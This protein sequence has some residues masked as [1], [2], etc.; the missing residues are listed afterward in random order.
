MDITI[1]VEGFVVPRWRVERKTGVLTSD[2]VIARVIVPF[3]EDLGV[4]VRQVLGAVQIDFRL[5]FHEAMSGV[6]P[7]TTPVFT[8]RVTELARLTKK[9]AG[10]ALDMTA[11]D[12]IELGNEEQPSADIL[13]ST[14]P[15]RYDTVAEA[16]AA[17]MDLTVGSFH[18]VG[19]ETST[20]YITHHPR[21][22]D[23]D[24]TVQVHG[25]AWWP[26]HG[27]LVCGINESIYGYSPSTGASYELARPPWASTDERQIEHLW[28]DG[29]DVYGISLPKSTAAA[30]TPGYIVKADLS[31][32]SPNVFGPPG[33]YTAYTSEPFKLWN[34]GRARILSS[35]AGWAEKFADI[36]GWKFYYKGNAI[37]LSG[38]V[39]SEYNNGP[40]VFEAERETA[41]A[42]LTYHVVAKDFWVSDSGAVGSFERASRARLTLGR[43]LYLPEETDVG[44]EYTNNDLRPADVTVYRMPGPLTY[45]VPGSIP[46]EDGYWVYDLG[47]ALPYAEKVG[48]LPAMLP[49]GY[50][51]FITHGQRAIIHGT[52]DPPAENVSGFEIGFS[53]MERR[54]AAFHTS[55][56]E[57]LVTAEDDVDI[58]TLG[59]PLGPLDSAGDEFERL[60]DRDLA[61]GTRTEVLG[62]PVGAYLVHLVRRSAT[63]GYVVFSHEVG[64]LG[65]Y[66]RKEPLVKLEIGRLDLEGGIWHYSKLKSLGGQ[67]DSYADIEETI[68]HYYP[69]SISYLN[70][71]LY[72]G[73]YHTCQRFIEIKDAPVYRAYADWEQDGT[74]LYLGHSYVEVNGYL[75]DKLK[76]GDRIRLWPDGAS[77][78]PCAPLPRTVL[79]VEWVTDNLLTKIKIAPSLDCSDGALNPADRVLDFI[80]S[81]MGTKGWEEYDGRVSDEFDGGPPKFQR[82]AEAR[83]LHT[84]FRAFDLSTGTWGAPI[85]FGREDVTEELTAEDDA[86]EYRATLTLGKSFPDTSTIEVKLG[87]TVV[88][89]TVDT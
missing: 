63:R 33:H 69:T 60:Y 2:K 31:G 4:T 71:K 23:A 82:E 79:N 64:L 88:G 62:F 54:P 1:A 85:D 11:F 7:H 57:H 48:V 77:G 17:E 19:L 83:E 66:G 3:L 86:E 20:P 52:D 6:L 27:L 47:N 44:L 68:Y 56:G 5:F 42:P 70:N 41:G 32:F 45:Y 14:E 75:T 9:K 51:S 59:D 28:V 24:A 43:N 76:V 58:S 8:G 13:L 12:L 81:T 16:L 10:D 18:G 40:T 30:A 38:P 67:P 34:A 26:T 65:A 50:Y 84:Y 73:Y 80:E 37:G 87:G 36:L 89:H 35:E 72:I 39:E 46:D 53:R 61:A 78:F 25:L 55:D 74:D 15:A 21:P 29:A 49:A 22:G